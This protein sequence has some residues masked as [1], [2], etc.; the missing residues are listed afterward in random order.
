M[1]AI[2]GRILIIDDE[3]T[4]LLGLTDVFKDEGYYVRVAANAREAL[5]IAKNEKFDI[6]YIDLMLPDMNGVDICREVKKLIPGCETFLIT[7]NPSKMEQYRE[8]FLRAGGRERIF[9]KPFD[10]NDMLAVTAGIINR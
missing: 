4:I 2:K 3:K 1:A 9:T 6:I 8:D 7:G 5:Q 10:I